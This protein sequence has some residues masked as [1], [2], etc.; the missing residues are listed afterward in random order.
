MN[1]LVV[2]QCFECGHYNISK[3]DGIRCRKCNGALKS[4]GNA[5]YID[6]GHSALKVEVSVK[7]TKL[8][9]KILMVFSDLIEDPHTPNWIKVKIRELILKEI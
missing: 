8:F 7:D 6:K 1:E 5:T 4:M 9:E 2:Y 3:R